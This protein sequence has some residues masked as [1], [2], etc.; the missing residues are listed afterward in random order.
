VPAYPAV[1]CYQQSVHKKTMK[2]ESNMTKKKKR[3]KYSD[4]RGGTQG[5]VC[6]RHGSSDYRWFPIVQ[7]QI[8]PHENPCEMWSELCDYGAGNPPSCTTLPSQ[9]SILTFTWEGNGEGV[10]SLLAAWCVYM[11]PKMV[12]GLT[13]QQW[14]IMYIFLC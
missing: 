5:S 3:C 1:K 2:Y 12:A 13:K 4:L 10:Q 11:L 7:A 6:L 9:L 14:G 8:Q